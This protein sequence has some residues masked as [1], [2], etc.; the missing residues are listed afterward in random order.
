MRQGR[1][2]IQVA[3]TAGAMPKLVENFK[4]F[5]RRNGL[6]VE[7]VR[8]IHLAL[9][10][11]VSNILQHG[12]R[13]GRRHRIGV[14]LAIEAGVLRVEVTDD[15]RPFNVLAIPDPPPGL[16]QA[17]LGKRRPGGLGIYLVKQLVE[18]LSYRRRHGLNHLVLERRLPSGAAESGELA[19]RRS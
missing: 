9:D 1:A 7:V 18:R 5:A 13:D 14:K 11:I 4:R 12:C 19:K 3:A 15:A 2:R 17:P 8:D 6:A 10:E 16:L